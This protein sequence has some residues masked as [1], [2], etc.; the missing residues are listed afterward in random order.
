M[1]PFDG[2]ISNTLKIQFKQAM[3]EI[4]RGCSVPCSL[5]YP[6][7]T[8]STCTDCQTS[9]SSQSHNPF[10]GGSI[11]KLT[12]NCPNCGGDG[13]IPI[14]NSTDTSMCVFF[15]YKKGDQ[16]VPG[17]VS[18]TDG[19]AITFCSID[20]IAAIKD[21]LYALLNTNINNSKRRVFIREGEPNPV[22]FGD[23]TYIITTWKVGA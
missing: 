7:T 18:A 15:N 19:D 6:I 12:T 8:Y 13:K 5:F 16:I 1:N 3:D 9:I 11:G 14:Q 22:G 2:I 17:I 21:C 4:I 20:Q 23:H 10:L